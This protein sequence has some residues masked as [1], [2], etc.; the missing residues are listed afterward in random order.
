MVTLN[1]QTEGLIIMSNILNESW[2]PIPSY[3]GF[4]SVSNIGNIRSENRT[5]FNSGIQ[6][7]TTLKGKLLKPA[8]DAHGYLRVNLSKDGQVKTIFVHSLVMLTFVGGRPVGADICHCDGNPLNNRLENLRYD[9]RAANIVDSKIHKTFSEAEIHPCA[10]LT[11]A[12]VIEIYNTSGIPATELAT[13]YN[14]NIGVIQGIWR[15]TSWKSVTSGGKATKQRGRNTYFRTKL[16]K[17]QGDIALYNR[18][19]KTGRKDGLGLRPTAERF[20]FDKDVIKSFY[21][22][23]DAGKNIIF[24]E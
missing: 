10:K 6:K 5:I 17:Q 4:Y 12:Q 1:G 13:R 7:T 14:V 20:G 16:S 15:G 8:P 2:L 21:T 24:S 3:E 11:N 22:A 23:V 9:T 19:N 18:A